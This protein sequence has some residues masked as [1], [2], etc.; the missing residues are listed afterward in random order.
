MKYHEDESKIEIEIK[1]EPMPAE[2]FY[3][4]C[5]TICVALFIVGLFAAIIMR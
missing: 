1:F 3:A 2:K 4:V 5:V